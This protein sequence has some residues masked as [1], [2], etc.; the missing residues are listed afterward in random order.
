MKTL[1]QVAQSIDNAIRSILEDA[2]MPPE[3]LTMYVS[4]HGIDY[5]HMQ[6]PE[7]VECTLGEDPFTYTKELIVVNG[8]TEYSFFADEKTCPDYTPE[9]VNTPEGEETPF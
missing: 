9:P 4:I 5:R 7:R 3:G 8:V 1:A 2:G 6:S